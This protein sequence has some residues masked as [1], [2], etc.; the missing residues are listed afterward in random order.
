MRVSP[1]RGW[2]LSGTLQLDDATLNGIVSALNQAATRLQTLSRSVQ[3]N[4]VDVVGA[5]ALIEGIDK[6][7]ENIGGRIGLLAICVNDLAGKVKDVGTTFDAA[8]QK[9]AHSAGGR[10]RVIA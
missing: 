4:D 2:D 3:G 5:D 9:L 10:H 7:Q 6:M 1:R 8:D